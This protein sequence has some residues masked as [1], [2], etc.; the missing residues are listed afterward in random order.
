MTG[1][2]F[3]ASV[4]WTALRHVWD[5]VADGDMLAIYRAYQ[6]TLGG[7]KGGRV[8]VVAVDLYNKV[9]EG[10]PL[11]PSDLQD[12][13]PSSCGEYAHEAIGPISEVFAAAR[14][15]AIP[16]IHMTPNV[17]DG[18]IV[19]T[20]R[21][22]GG[23]DSAGRADQWEFHPAL[24]PV[25]GELIIVKERASAFYGTQ[26]VAELVSR[27]I[28]TVVIVGGESTSGCVRASVVDACSNGFH[29]VVVE[30]GGVFDRLWLNHQVSLFDLHH[31]YADVMDSHT[32]VGLMEQLPLVAP[33]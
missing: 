7:I 21:R 22:A 32:I 6:R 23:L 11:P 1:E 8:A 30:D 25:T 31:K 33:R 20:N 24:A 12:T 4:E 15:A 5:D 26:L 9:F 2:E 17:S 3:I 28:S 27:G 19:A 18:S 10:G 13:Y 16:I 14:R 29:T